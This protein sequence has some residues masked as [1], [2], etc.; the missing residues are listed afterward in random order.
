MKPQDERIKVGIWGLGRAGWGMHCPE[1]DRFPKLFEI[2]AGCDLEVE[3]TRSLAEKYGARVYTDPEDFLRDEAVELV[4]VTTRSGD[5]VAHAELALRAGKTVFLEKPIAL[6]YADALRLKELEAEHPGKLYFRHNR[7]FEA[8]FQHVREIIDS[9][10]LGEI[11]EIK[12][13]RQ[14]YQRRDDWQALTSCGGGMLNNWGPHLIDHALQLLG[15]PLRDLWCDLR[16]VAAV[17]DAEDTFKV[18]FRGENGRLVDLEVS[19]GAVMPGNC[20]EV[21]GT[22]GALVCPDEQD[23]KLKYL[24]P[25]QEFPEAEARPGN[26]GF[27]WDFGQASRLRWR[28]ETI[29]VEPKENCTQQDIYRY[30]YAAIRDGIPFPVKMEEALEV[31]RVTEMIRQRAAGR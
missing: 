1:L 26:P 6:T 3:R 20:Y 29:M 21:Y 13:N 25:G 19:G 7:R 2:V 10:L 31:V 24:T 8:A 28:R 11:Y 22:R 5:H 16:R 23:I 30:L 18:L 17:G 4:S 12:L 14:F 15:A 9:G 27:G